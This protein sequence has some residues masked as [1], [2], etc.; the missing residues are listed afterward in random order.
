M[1]PPLENVRCLPGTAIGVAL[2]AAIAMGADSCST[3]TKS[4]PDA[5]SSGRSSSTSRKASTAPATAGLGD[6]I[7]L[8]GQADGSKIMV[9]LTRIIDPVPAGEFD[10]PAAGNRFIGVRVRLTNQGSTTY[11]DSPSNG[12]ALI[13]SGDEQADQALVAEGPCGG[14][15]SSAAKISPGTSQAGCIPFEAPRGKRPIRFQFALDSG[16]GPSTGEWT[17][18]P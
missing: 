5:P 18:R 16:F 13:V 7:T 6:A 17:L 3:E 2:F 15:F 1:R 11:D 14:E 4:T 12:A 9:R 8:D 10:Q